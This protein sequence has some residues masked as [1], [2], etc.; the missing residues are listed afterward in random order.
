MPKK[1]KPPHVG[2]RKAGKKTS[3]IVSGAPS[4]TASPDYASTTGGMCLWNGE[5]YGPRDTVVAVVG[6]DSAGEEIKHVL[7]CS[8]SGDGTWFDTDELGEAI[9]GR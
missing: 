6:T 2:V 5:H 7:L 3:R 4:P 9:P 1:P 8:P